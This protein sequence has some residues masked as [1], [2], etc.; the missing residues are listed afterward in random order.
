MQLAPLQM[1]VPLVLLGA[2]AWSAGAVLPGGRGRPARSLG[3]VLVLSGGSVGLL[4]VVFLAIGT[5]LAADPVLAL[6]LIGLLVLLALLAIEVLARRGR[7]PAP[8]EARG[9]ED[10]GGGQR[11]PDP[12]TPPWTP[13]A[14]GPDAGPCGV[15][16]DRFDDLRSQWERV[17]A[18]TR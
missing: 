15:A 11:R 3:A 17:P 16:W 13:P 2:L 4:Y 6:V 9:D 5:A 18:G 10:G 7:P 8:D 14:C 12:S 1:L